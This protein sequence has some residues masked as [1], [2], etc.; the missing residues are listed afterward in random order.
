MVLLG[1]T[2]S[3]NKFFS[4]EFKIETIYGLLKITI[5]QDDFTKQGKPRSRYGNLV[6]IYSKFLDVNRA[7]EYLKQKNGNIYSGKVNY[8]LSGGNNVEKN[9]D[10]NFDRFKCD[11]EK[12]LIKKNV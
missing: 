2:K 8:D 12:I 1:T 4:Y 6:S 3:D 5:F 10:A 11:L 9:W 7:K